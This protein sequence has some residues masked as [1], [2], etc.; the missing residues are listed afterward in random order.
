MKARVSEKEALKR[1]RF[2]LQ[3]IPLLFMIAGIGV[4]LGFD[5][6]TKP[7]IYWATIIGGVLGFVLASIWWS[8]AVIKWKLWAYSEVL[9]PKRLEERAVG[10]QYIHPRFSLLAKTEWAS[11]S[12]RAELER[13]YDQMDSSDFETEEVDT[14]GLDDYYERKLSKTGLYIGAALLIAGLGMYF[15]SKT[16]NRESL[17]IAVMAGIYFLIELNKLRHPKHLRIDE[18]G[19]YYNGSTYGWEVISSYK[20]AHPRIA[21]KYFVLSM[22]LQIPLVGYD[23]DE[24]E[25]HFI[26]SVEI[27]LDDLE[28]DGWSL[29]AIMDGYK[30]RFLKNHPNIDA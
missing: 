21:A 20:I 8:K 13:L 9:N 28:E 27:D 18:E 26:S 4:G 23:D 2:Q 3:I 7:N 22:D 14:R 6:P 12:E 5:V 1:A 25:N 30:S 24:D 15:F 11:K 17:V 10:R 29:E 16:N 19:V